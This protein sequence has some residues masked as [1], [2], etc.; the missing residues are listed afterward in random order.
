VTHGFAK[1]K[2][3]IHLSGFSLFFLQNRGSHGKKTEKKS[4]NSLLS[5]VKKTRFARHDAQ[6]SFLCIMASKKK[7]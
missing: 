4:E 6:I 3:K 5:G 7:K 2:V 1:K